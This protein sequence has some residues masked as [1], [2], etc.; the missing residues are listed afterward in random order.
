MP[1]PARRGVVLAF[2]SGLLFPLSPY[3]THREGFAKTSDSER[4]QKG[5]S[6]N[7]F[8]LCLEKSKIRKARIAVSL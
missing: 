7:Y 8:S 3:K 2:S 5:N 6:L 4:R 1:G